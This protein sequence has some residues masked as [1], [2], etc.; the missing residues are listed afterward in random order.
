MVILVAMIP[1]KEVKGA[2]LP[3]PPEKTA[4]I[5]PLELELSDITWDYNGRKK[6]SNMYPINTTELTAYGSQYPYQSGI[7]DKT[8]ETSNSQIAI[9]YS[10]S[11]DIADYDLVNWYSCEATTDGSIEREY[12]NYLY[13]IQ[14]SD[15]VSVSS[16][17]ATKTYFD[18]YDGNG[19][20][21]NR[22]YILRQGS[23]DIKQY[24]ESN[25]IEDNARYKFCF[26]VTVYNYASTYYISSGTSSGPYEFYGY[27]SP[28]IVSGKKLEMPYF[29]GF[30]A[31]SDL[32]VVILD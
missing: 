23:I 1:Y 32:T 26:A 29:S 10:D 13:L 7:P 28:A 2:A 17:A 14:E 8:V 5:L 18:V 9:M 21:V 6:I 27:I 24:R 12:M 22:P 16:Q 25:N 31:R 11:F 15:T 20:K 30:E 3:E 4:Y 19:T